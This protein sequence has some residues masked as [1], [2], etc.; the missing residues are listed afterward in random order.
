VR[1]LSENIN[2]VSIVGRFLEHS[3]VY[4]FSGCGEEKLFISSADLMTRNLDR[5]MEVMCP[6]FDESIK[7]RIKQML[8]ILLKD[9]AKGRVMQP[10]GKYT[11]LQV[12]D[13]INNSQMVQ[14]DICVHDYEKRHPHMHKRAAGNIKHKL[15]RAL[16]V[17]GK[18]IS[19][20][21]YLDPESE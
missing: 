5:R 3:R 15:G 16:I 6:V 21:Y 9:T 18:K 20:D 13:G 19:S 14:Y 8:D 7:Q 4:W 17:L 11:R 10:C 2:V 12:G 1:N